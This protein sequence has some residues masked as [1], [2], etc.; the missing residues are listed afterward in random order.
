MNLAIGHGLQ[1]TIA[2]CTGRTTPLSSQCFYNVFDVQ[3]GGNNNHQSGANRC[4]CNK[5]EI[6][7]TSLPCGHRQFCN[8]CIVSNV[9]TKCGLCDQYIQHFDMDKGLLSE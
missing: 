7:T 9:I 6:N 4:Q 5:N 8:V 3:S 1:D 2:F